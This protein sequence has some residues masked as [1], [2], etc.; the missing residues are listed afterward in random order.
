MKSFAAL[1]CGAFLVGTQ[2]LNTKNQ[3]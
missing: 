2:A 3:A 1:L